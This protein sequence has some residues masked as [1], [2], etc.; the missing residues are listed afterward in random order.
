MSKKSKNL[1]KRVKTKEENHVNN[2]YL[3]SRRHNLEILKFTTY[4]LSK[5]LISGLIMLNN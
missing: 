2:Q 3:W 1:A 5:K 4:L